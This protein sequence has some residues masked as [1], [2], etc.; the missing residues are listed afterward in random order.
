MRACLSCACINA[1]YSQYSIYY[2]S[3]PLL[4]PHFASLSPQVEADR[5]EDLGTVHRR[6]PLSEYLHAL[7]EEKKAKAAKIAENG[8]GGGSG[9]EGGGSEG[10]KK[11]SKSKK[12]EASCRNRSRIGGN[13][14]NVVV[15]VVVVLVIVVVVRLFARIQCAYRSFRLCLCSTVVFVFVLCF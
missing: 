4:S 13:V 9:G 8:G 7:F 2:T 11:R 6:L 1:W 12:N 3:T 14:D 15:V 5:G 10:K